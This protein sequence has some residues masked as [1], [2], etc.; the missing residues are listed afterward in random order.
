MKRR[1]ALLLL[2]LGLLTALLVLGLLAGFVPQT[3]GPEL[4][5][6]AN[7]RVVSLTPAD[8]PAPIVPLGDGARQWAVRRPVTAAS[9]KAGAA[10]GRAGPAAPHG[11]WPPELR[12]AVGEPGGFAPLLSLDGASPP[13]LLGSLPPL[14]GDALD[15]G[16]RPLR[17]LTGPGTLAGYSPW[18]PP[19][20][21][22]VAPPFTG[23]DASPAALHARAARYR[24]L[25]EN[26]ARRYDLDTDLVYAIIHSESDFSPTLVSNKSAMGLMQILPDTASDEVH[27]F[28]YGHRGEIGFDELRVP[29][30]NI[31]YGTT[32]LHILLT[33]YFAGV[34]DELAREYCVVAAYNMG[35]NRFLRLYGATDAAAVARINTM[36]ATELYADLTSRLPARETRFYV[37][38]VRRMKDHYAA[39][40]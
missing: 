19:A 39:L 28:L 8:L 13:L 5:R 18:Q 21:Q 12:A 32:Y 25:V 10:Q 2:M 7:P 22:A 40:R 31:R 3:E 35:P 29:E 14:Y 38:K 37:A 15:T 6:R 20:P 1:T 33:R 9:P 11:A 24:R 34:E 27:P 4:R 30:V 17:W 16:G 26:F 23:E 36:S